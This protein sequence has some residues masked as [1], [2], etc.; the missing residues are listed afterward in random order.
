VGGAAPR[1]TRFQNL[2]QQQQQQQ[3][4]AQ[5]ATCVMGW[6]SWP[7]VLEKQ[8]LLGFSCTSPAAAAKDAAVATC[9]MNCL[10]ACIQLW[11]HKC[12]AA[13]LLHVFHLI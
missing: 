5:G 2:Q 1:T 13:Q 6:E 11:M 4:Q 9:V 7:T 10:T 12:C 8:N 3:Q